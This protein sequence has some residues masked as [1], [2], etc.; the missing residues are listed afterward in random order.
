MRHIL[1][2]FARARH[3]LKRGGDAKRVSLD[4]ALVI[5]QE[6]QDDFVALDDAL[7]SL[8]AI[9]TSTLSRSCIRTMRR[10]A[11]FILLRPTSLTAFEI[12]DSEVLLIR[13]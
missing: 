11:N 8:A 12:V 2:D 9:T 1:V 5:A 3:N 7:S 10:Q 13:V 6:Q 4:E